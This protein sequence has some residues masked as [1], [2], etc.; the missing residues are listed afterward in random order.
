MPRL[1][2]RPQTNTAIRLIRI[3]QI[4]PHTK[5][6]W[7]SVLWMEFHN[8]VVDSI[9]NGNGPG[10]L[11]APT[12]T[13]AVARSIVEHYYRE[14]GLHDYAKK[15]LQDDVYEE[16]CSHYLG[17]KNGQNDSANSEPKLCYAPS[18][19]NTA[20]LL[21]SLRFGHSMVR[22]RYDYNQLFS[23]DTGAG[24]G[25][26]LRRLRRLVTVHCSAVEA[27]ILIELIDDLRNSLVT[28]YGKEIHEMIRPDEPL[29]SFQQDLP[30]DDPLDF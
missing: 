6:L 4:Q 24:D 26:I 18:E 27:H 23:V 21:Y 17:Q 3:C 28:V 14:I 20:A 5:A 13:F 15:L 30:F 11:G 19:E 10:G 16:L 8:K 12:T 22:A 25:A 1:R 2:R 9:E 29:T 7:S